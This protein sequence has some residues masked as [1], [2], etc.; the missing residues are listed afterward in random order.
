MDAVRSRLPSHLVCRRTDSIS[1]GFRTCNSRRFECVI[2]TSR[3][4]R[5]RSIRMLA[6]SV[7]MGCTRIHFGVVPFG[8][9]DKKMTKLSLT[10]E[11]TDKEGFAGY[12]DDLLRRALSSLD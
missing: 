8:S 12:L 1:A 6:L 7:L 4:A 5:K 11:A 10:Q 2:P 3:W 9:N